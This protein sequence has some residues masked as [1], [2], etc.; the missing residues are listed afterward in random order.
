MT[1]D[2]GG[3]RRSRSPSAGR[4]RISGLVSPSL[5]AR[6]GRPSTGASIVSTASSAPETLVASI[7][8]QVVILPPQLGRYRAEVGSG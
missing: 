4:H 7:L 3:G 5:G 8:A 6:G 2:P 1:A